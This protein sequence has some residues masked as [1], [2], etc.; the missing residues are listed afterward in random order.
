[1][2]KLLAKFGMIVC[3]YGCAM[4]KENIPI[5]EAPKKSAYPMP[6]PVRSM[7]IYPKFRIDNKIAKVSIIGTGTGQNEISTY[8]TKFI[9]ETT[10]IKVV[11]PGNL[12]S[13]LGGRIIEYRTGL[14]GTESQIIAQMLQIDHII[15][16][17]EKISPHEDYKYGGPAY[18][19]I[20]L[21]IMNSQMETY[22]SNVKYV[23]CYL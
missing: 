8:L 11:E 6:M 1:M 2:V 13:I 17:E 20:N 5:N 4:S 10:S 21:K 3:F 18:D 16:F 15:L 9:T 7:A 22:L 23:L 14:T 19:Q 12:K